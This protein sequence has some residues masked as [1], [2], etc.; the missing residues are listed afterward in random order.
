MDPLKWQDKS[1]I[2]QMKMG[3]PQLRRQLY[4][5]YAPAFFSAICRLVPQTGDREQLMMDVFAAIFSQLPSFDPDRQRLYS[6]MFSILQRR[7][8]D[9]HERS[10]K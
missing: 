9:W 10:A 8:L 7:L 5:E 2:D 1:L 3:D 6:W 4:D